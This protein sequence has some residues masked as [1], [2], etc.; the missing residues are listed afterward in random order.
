MKQILTQI[1]NKKSK[2]NKKKSE[3]KKMAQASLKVMKKQEK[4]VLEFELPEYIAVK[5]CAV[6]KASFGKKISKLMKVNLKE[7][8]TIQEVNNNLNF[9]QYIATF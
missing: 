1:K 3:V 8:Q 2:I 9:R 7:T 5:E 6:E 4:C